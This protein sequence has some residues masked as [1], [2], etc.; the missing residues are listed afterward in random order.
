MI[1]VRNGEL[2]DPGR[3]QVAINDEGFLYGDSLFETLRAEGSRL[4]W[5]DDHL[6]RLA[7]ACLL[8]GI[9]FDRPLAEKGLDLI[10]RRLEP[11]ISRVRLTISRGTD[12]PVQFI[13][14][15]PY[16]PPKQEA[17][18]HGVFCCLAPNRRVNAVSHLPQMKRGNY[19]DCI[20]ALRHAHRNGC[21]EALFCEPD[22]S[23]LE[24]TISNLFIL[25]DGILLTPPAGGKVLPGISRSRILKAAPEL[26]IATIEHDLHRDLLPHADEVILSNSLFGLLPVRR[27]GDQ[28]FTAGPVATS[29]RCA[30]G[31]PFDDPGNADSS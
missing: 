3:S 22:G 19:A 4:L 9:P 5:T 12:G 25:L 30:L 29:L 8:S 2:V 28:E 11:P 20:Y 23:L 13:T 1:A 6:Q 26:G 17:Y 14:A 7:D 10:S 24:G 18:R 15:L 27:V 31:A 16:Q 21:F